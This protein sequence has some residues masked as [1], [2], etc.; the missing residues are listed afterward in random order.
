MSIRSS[1]NPSNLRHNHRN[2][3]RH[4]STSSRRYSRRSSRH[5]THLCIYHCMNWNSPMSRSPH[6]HD[7]RRMSMNRRNLRC[8]SRH[9]RWNSYAH[10]H[11]NMLQ[12]IQSIRG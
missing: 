5:Y 9:S 12:S 10:S 11:L 1:R 3:R 4:N 7:R 6:I 8:R 2:K